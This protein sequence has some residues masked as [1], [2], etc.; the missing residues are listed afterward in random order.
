MSE[1]DKMEISKAVWEAHGHLSV[2]SVEFLE[3]ILENP[4]TLRRANYS[5]VLDVYKLA[6]F[7]PWPTFVNRATR[8]KMEEAAVK[9]FYLV[10]S[11]FRCI[12]ANDPVKISE[13]YHLPVDVVK[14]QL[15]AT[16]DRHL[17]NLLARG[18][19]VY[20]PSG[21]KCLEFNISS[22]IAGLE[23]PVWQPLYLKIPVI[24]RF[25]EAQGIK[26]L[27]E[28]I[29]SL[30]LSHLLEAFF[31]TAAGDHDEIN[32]ALVSPPSRGGAKFVVEL[33]YL[34]KIYREF[35]SLKY[36]NLEGE[37]IFCDY[38]ELETGGAPGGVRYKGKKI[39]ILVET[40]TGLVPQEILQQFKQ[41]NVQLYNGPITRLLTN[42]LNL[43][44]LSEHEDSDVFSA[45]ARDT[46]KKYIPWTRKIIPGSLID[47]MRSNK[48]MLV[49]KS[50]EGYGG[51]KVFVGRDIAPWKWEDLI[52]LALGRE[53]WL[54][55]EYVES[56]PYL[57]QSG[58]YGCAE[59]LAVWG[60]FVFGSRYAGSWVRV[61]SKSNKSSVVN[62]HLGAEESISL[63]V[64]K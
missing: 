11:I 2:H 57:Y 8:L 54:V 21:F 34:K 18:D 29:I 52:Q 13:Y 33:A 56:F 35:L 61:L 58:E 6:A 10:K 20:S 39:H 53:N 44:L 37:I 12:F 4:G 7:Q 48:D 42:K 49:I 62:S 19:F 55:Q 36:G 25:L 64:E 23:M 59:H 24:H 51:D 40:Y 3:Y 26:I 16:D 47:S 9:V 32:I 38:Q 5:E 31:E 63:E 22:D 30:L 15:D 50:P 1:S 28:N 14:L 45:E 17:D 46:I 41:G 60:L 27:N 43:A